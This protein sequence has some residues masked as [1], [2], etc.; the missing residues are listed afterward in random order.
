MSEMVGTHGTL[1]GS[2]RKRNKSN[3]PTVQVNAYKCSKFYASFLNFM[4][5][6]EIY[7]LG[8]SRLIFSHYLLLL[9]LN[10]FMEKAIIR[11]TL[12]T[13]N[14]EN[15]VPHAHRLVRRIDNE[16]L[17]DPHDIEVSQDNNFTAEY[18]YMFHCTTF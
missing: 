16:D 2:G 9:Q 17:D 14:E 3:V 6:Q 7:N 4:N 18:V 5:H 12:V 15:R 10:N 13:S 8:L 11:C 1:A